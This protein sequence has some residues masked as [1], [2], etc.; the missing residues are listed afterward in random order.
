MNCPRIVKESQSLVKKG[1]GIQTWSK[2]AI[3]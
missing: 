2:D 1:G 3:H